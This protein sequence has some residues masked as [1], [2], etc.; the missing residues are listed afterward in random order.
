M[1]KLAVP[2][3]VLTVRGLAG[4]AQVKRH[5]HG[6]PEKALCLYSL[7]RIRELQAEGH[8]IYPGSIGEN[9]T[10]EGIEWARLGPGRRLALGD[11]ALVEIRSYTVPC[12]TIAASFAGGAYDR[13]S[14]GKHPG[15]S[16]LY[17][18]VLRAG[19]IAAGQ[20][21]RVLD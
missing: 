2:E 11:E 3:A 16:R 20:T 17:A 9:V 12:R 19:R 7:E 18:R 21:L 8:P 1:P 6:G 10:I 4:D 15:Y 5:I 14:Q 13:V